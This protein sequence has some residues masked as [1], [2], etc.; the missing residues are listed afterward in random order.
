MD[1]CSPLLVEPRPKTKEIYVQ[2]FFEAKED[3]NNDRAE[4]EEVAKL[5]RTK[6]GCPATMDST[7]ITTSQQAKSFKPGGALLIMVWPR[8]T[9]E[10]PVPATTVDKHWRHSL[11]RPLW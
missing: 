10:P 4:T 5:L 9:D 2:L 3:D 6:L 11:P 8:G 1:L 7:F